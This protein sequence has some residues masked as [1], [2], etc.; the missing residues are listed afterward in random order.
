MNLFRRH[1]LAFDDKS[2][3]A[4]ARESLNDV[5][6]FRGITR[7]MNLR[8]GFFSIR[9]ELFKILVEM[10]QRLVFDPACF[11]P[12]VLPIRKTSGS[13]KTP[14]AEQRSHVPQSAAQLHVLKRRARVCVEG[15]AG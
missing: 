2:R 14:L 7:P 1:A 10:K 6:S 9:G 3:G 11:S 13:R 8:A 5:V 12:Q 15:L 4:F